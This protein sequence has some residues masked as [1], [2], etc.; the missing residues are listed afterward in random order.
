MRPN[1]I[2]QTDNSNKYTQNNKYE[3]EYEYKHKSK[4]KSKCRDRI[5][6]AS[7]L[8]EGWNENI[9]RTNIFE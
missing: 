9:I 8:V 2:E 4:S 3:Y 6:C 1:A 7:K 5:E